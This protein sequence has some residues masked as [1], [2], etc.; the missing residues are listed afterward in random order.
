MSIQN[1]VDCDDVDGEG[2]VNNVFEN[3][4]FFTFCKTAAY[5]AADKAKVA[6]MQRKWKITKSWEGKGGKGLNAVFLHIT[7]KSFLP[8]LSG[9]FFV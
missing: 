3:A 9:Y 2:I 4:F 1:N 7:H 5:A 6:A 8:S